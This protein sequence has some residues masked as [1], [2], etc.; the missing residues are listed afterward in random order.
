MNRLAALAGIPLLVLSFAPLASAVPTVGKETRTGDIYISG[1]TGYQEIKAE[2]SALPK[3]VSKTANECGFFKVAPSESNPIVATSNLKLNSDSPFVVS[4]IPTQAVPKCTNGQLSGNTAPAAK[5]RDSEGAVYFTGLVPY[6]QHTLTYM[7]L[8]GLKSAKANTCGQVK[9]AN[10]G[11]YANPTGTITIK[12]K[13][14]A[15]TI[16][17]IDLATISS[18]SGGPVC[19][20]GVSYFSSDWPTP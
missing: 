13:D 9:L 2:Y 6:S 19:K 18:Y 11:I 1:L 15:T 4:G 14:Q 20:N 16:S 10:K 8:P 7:D 12:S 3:A 17:T 5:L